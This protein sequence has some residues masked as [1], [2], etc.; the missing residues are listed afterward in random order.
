MGL[1]VLRILLDVV[2]DLVLDD[3]VLELFDRVLQGK[4]SS[5]PGLGS[6]SG[7]AGAVLNGSETTS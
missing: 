1:H 3:L 4:F 6:L 5:L 2:R 7:K